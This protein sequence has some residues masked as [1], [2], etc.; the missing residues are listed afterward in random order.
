MLFFFLNNNKVRDISLLDDL[1]Y[2]TT[3]RKEEEY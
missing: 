3:I 2:V 1:N